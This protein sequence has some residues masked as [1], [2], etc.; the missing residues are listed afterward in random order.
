[1]SRNKRLKLSI[2]ERE[3]Q[4]DEFVIRAAGSKRQSWEDQFQQMA[5]A[6]DDQLLDGDFP[7]TGWETEKWIW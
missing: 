5:A 3:T 2:V 6:G 1:M 4:K 7:L